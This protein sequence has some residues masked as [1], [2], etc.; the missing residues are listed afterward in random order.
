MMTY[1]ALGRV[2]VSTGR[3]APGETF[4]VEETEGD[5]LVAL[6]MAEEVAD[7]A[8]PPASAKPKPQKV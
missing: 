2:S 3:V 6:G 4:T 8:P 1:K 7:A 5:P